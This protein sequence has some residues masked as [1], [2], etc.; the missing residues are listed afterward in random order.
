MI[1]GCAMS[2]RGMKSKMVDQRCPQMILRNILQGRTHG[3]LYTWQG[4]DFLGPKRPCPLGT[5]LVRT[6]PKH[7]VAIWGK[8]QP[9]GAKKRGGFMMLFTLLSLTDSLTHSLTHSLFPGMTRH[10]TVMAWLECKHSSMLGA[11]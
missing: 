4:S 2:F 3:S 9:G 1:L 7:R 8:L 6:Q 10:I 11:I 5:A